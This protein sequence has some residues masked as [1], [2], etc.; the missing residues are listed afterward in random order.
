MELKIA[1]LFL[2][3]VVG[4]CAGVAA[5][6]VLRADRDYF[7]ELVRLTDRLSFGIKC[8]NESVL[9]IMGEAAV[10][11]R[12]G[13]QIKAFVSAS[14]LP[15]LGLKKEIY[16]EVCSFFGALGLSDSAAQTEMLDGYAARFK[17]YREQYEA[18]YTKYGALSVKLGFAIGLAIG[19]LVI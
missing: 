15:R 13:K 16:S 10:G 7:A 1:L 8:K 4:A 9:E 12:L 14:E 11:G 5:C 19:I 3:S 2:F 18:N 17:V 6:K